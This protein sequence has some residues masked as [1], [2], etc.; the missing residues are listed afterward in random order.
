MNKKTIGKLIPLLLV[1]MFIVGV[2]AETLGFYY[3]DDITVHSEAIL[4]VN[5]N[6]VEGFNTSSDIYINA[7]EY[8]WQNYTVQYIGSLP[9]FKIG[10]EQTNGMEGVSHTVYIDTVELTGTNVTLNKGEVHDIS[11][12]FTGDY[13]LASGSEVYQLSFVPVEQ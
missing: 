4:K 6:T 9:T 11:V 12:L 8:C 3:T 13:N 7:S 10:V 2:T 5:G 1:G